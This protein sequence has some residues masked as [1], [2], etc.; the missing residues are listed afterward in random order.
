M[1]PGAPFGAAPPGS[2]SRASLRG[3]AAALFVALL[4]GSGPA[5]SSES[6][7][8][9]FGLFKAKH[10]SSVDPAL[11]ARLV[12]ESAFPRTV[13]TPPQP[14]W[15]P[16]RHVGVSAAPPGGIITAARGDQPPAEAFV[17]P[18]SGS[19][20]P[21]AVVSTY[22]PARR[23]SIWELDAQG[24]HFAKPRTAVFDR[25]QS[26]WLMYSASSVLALPA[27]QLLI[28][29]G[30]HK[31]RAGS[32][33]YVY[34]LAADRMRPLGDIEPDWAQGVPFRH[35]DTLVA[36]PDVLLV[37]YRTESERLG[38]QRYVNHHEHV[39]LFSPRH[40]DGLEVLTLGLDDGAIRDWGMVGRTLWLNTV[41]DRQAASGR[42]VW[43]LDLGRVL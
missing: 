26:A 2:L 3:C 36:A 27:D 34:D 9:I 39:L 20:P 19:R 17:A 24:M 1:T 38:P 23:A 8:M 33:L 31:P 14:A 42:F 15:P 4:A 43:S 41:D 21:V 32:G 29:L 6:D 22:E 12:R 28:Q 25:G 40:R 16:L 37:V 35:V 30:F 13:A 18:A 11:G 10:A 5:R 7:N